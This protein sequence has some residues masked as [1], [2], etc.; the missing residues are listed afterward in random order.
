MTPSSRLTPV[1]ALESAP[2]LGTGTSASDFGEVPPAAPK[3]DVKEALA[4]AGAISGNSAVL[5]G[6][7][8]G[9]A[10]LSWSSDEGT[11]RSSGATAEVNHGESASHVR[12]GAGAAAPI[13]SVAEPE[14]MWRGTVDTSLGAA[15]G[16]ERVADRGGAPLIDPESERCGP[17][18]PDLGG[19]AG[20]ERSADGAAASCVPVADRESAHSGSAEAV[21][22]D[23]PDCERVAG[24]GGAQS[25]HVGHGNADP[26]NEAGRECAA[27]A[28]ATLSAPAVDFERECCGPADATFADATRRGGSAAAVPANESPSSEPDLHRCPGFIGSGPARGADAEEVDEAVAVIE[29]PITQEDFQAVYSAARRPVVLRGLDV[30]P[31]VEKWTPEYLAGLP[32]SQKTVVSTHVCSDPSGRA[33]VSMVGFLRW[34]CAWCPCKFGK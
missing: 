26:R 31:A 25:A 14:S 6:D 10:S 28:G 33:W 1:P 19:E 21:L 20:H 3:E 13:A 7:V 23:S 18:S 24:G 16:R 17:A 11:C 15:V 4:A 29:G 32:S 5:R 12:G 34:H 22:R 30:G 2:A 9:Q 27:G 8:P